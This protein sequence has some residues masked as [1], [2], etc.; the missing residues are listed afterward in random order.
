[1]LPYVF[2]YLFLF[3]KIGNLLRVIIYYGTEKPAGLHFHA[4]A[5]GVGTCVNP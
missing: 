2:F 1:M 4:H 5:H 3:K